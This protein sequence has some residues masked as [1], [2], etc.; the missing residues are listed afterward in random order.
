MFVSKRKGMTGALGFAVGLI[1]ALLSLLVINLRHRSFE[2]AYHSEQV[3]ATTNGLQTLVLEFETGLRGFVITHQERYLDPW[4][5]A[6]AHYP[7]QMALL[8]RLT[9][10]EP[11]QQARARALKKR[12]DDYLSAYSLT[13]MEFL[14]R[15]PAAARIVAAAAQQVNQIRS[16]FAKLVT[17]EET[18]EPQRVDDSPSQSTRRRSAQQQAGT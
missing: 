4:R 18:K 11:A 13:F 12:I 10:H 16:Q 2:G 14:R 6:Q 7:G 15:N 8:I 17:A 3:I 1:V 5:R 9:A